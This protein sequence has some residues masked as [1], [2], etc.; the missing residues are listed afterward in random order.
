MARSDVEVVCRYYEPDAQ[1]RMKG[2]VGV[3]IQDCYHGHEGVRA[4]Y[5]DIDEAFRDWSWTIRSVADGG[6]RIAVRADFIGYGRTS[7]A[8]TALNDGGTAVRFS[9]RGLI[10]SQEWFVQQGGWAEVLEA[11]GLSE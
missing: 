5:A 1:V 4:I 11:V 2:M 10:A 3:G 7:G 6:D 9:P 8:M